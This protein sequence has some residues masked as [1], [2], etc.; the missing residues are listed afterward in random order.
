MN[1]DK[2]LERGDKIESL[3]NKS[4]TLNEN[5]LVFSR[6]A[7]TLRKTEWYRNCKYQLVLLLFFC[8]IAAVVTLS[9]CGTDFHHFCD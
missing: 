4:Q 6:K 1:M 2:V 8:A 7:I 3:L 9:V 5:A